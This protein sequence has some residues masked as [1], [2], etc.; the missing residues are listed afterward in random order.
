MEK[1]ESAQ[2]S[3]DKRS[4]FYVMFEDKAKRFPDKMFIW[5]ID[6][7]NSIT[8]GQAYRLC[9]QIGHFFK[10]KG[11]KANDRVVLLTENSME[12]LILFLAI[13]AYGATYCP[14]NMEV[15]EK[16]VGELVEK[17][18]PR[19]ALW[20]REIDGAKLGKGAPGEWIAFDEWHLDRGTSQLGKADEFFS[21]VAAY[22][23]T[24]PALPACTREDYCVIIHTSGTTAKPKG[25]T[26]T[27]GA[28]VDQT[29]ALALSLG[30]T[31]DDTVLEYRPFSWGSAQLL[32][33]L[34]PFALGA[35]VV[36]AKKFSQSRFFDWLKEYRITI[37]ASVPTAVNMLMS[38]PVEV[39]AL[40]FPNLRFITSSSAPLSVTQHL[41]FEEMYGI[42]IIQMYGMSEA[43]WMAGN[44]PDQRKIG[45]VG[46][47]MKYQEVKIIGNNG[48][49]LPPGM[50]GEIE[51]GGRQKSYGYLD[52]A[53]TVVP[54][55]DER[56]KTGDV[57]FLDED[58]FLHVTGRMKDL[59]IRGGV[60]VAPAEIDNIL[61]EHPDIAEAATVGVPNPIYGE[62]VVCYVTRS[63]GKA[64]TP[65]SVL[66]HCRQRLPDFKLPKEIL[67]V[68][69]IPKNDRGKIDRMGLI[70][71]WKRS[72]KG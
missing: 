8:Y 72:H 38:R 23:E 56:L 65:E 21:L 15:T 34:T 2:P 3:N 39:K 26:H 33:F 51:V 70:E 41:K 27:Y 30:M 9:N 14:L 53:G 6:Q 67:F 42:K 49:A 60:N 4:P 66:D 5:S 7:N 18:Q 24:T 28:I 50:I 63:P 32:G 55:A 31:A 12:N 10:A 46:R 58:G 17:I 69:S 68:E 45:T 1:T 54:Y 44:H 47:P 25:V 35:T 29:E 62:E 22:P 64:L 37:A 19:L 48:E 40:E 52:E 59:I 16:M 43:G 36:M 13:L 61:M 71:E 57:G 11:L 20:A